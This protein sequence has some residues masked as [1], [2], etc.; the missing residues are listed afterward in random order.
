MVIIIII[1]IIVI[2]KITIIVLIIVILP[3]IKFYSFK[4]CIINRKKNV[5]LL[6]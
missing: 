4:L 6:K 5:L 2:I 1:I 3:K